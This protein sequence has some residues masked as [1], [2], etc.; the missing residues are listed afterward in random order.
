MNAPSEGLARPWS[1]LTTP[2]PKN[3]YPLRRRAK[4]DEPFLLT[5]VNGQPLVLSQSGMTPLLCPLPSHNHQ[6]TISEMPTST[7]RC[8]DPSPFGSTSPPTP[9]ELWNARHMLQ[10]LRIKHIISLPTTYSGL[11]MTLKQMTPGKAQQLVSLFM[12]WVPSGPEALVALQR[13]TELSSTGRGT[14]L[15]LHC[16]RVA[17][18]SSV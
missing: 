7:R 2:P 8:S 1:V 6:M 4:R 5:H 13:K 12:A 15:R 3:H 11:D 14:C 16:H 17:P 10:Q 18:P 9:S